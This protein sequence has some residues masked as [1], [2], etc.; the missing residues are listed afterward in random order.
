MM[1]ADPRAL[2]EAVEGGLEATAEDLRVAKTCL[3]LAPPA[4]GA[5][6]FHCQ[7]AIEKLLKGFLML[8]AK[9]SRKTH[10]L[11]QLSAA[12]EASFP[13]ISDL[14]AAAKD[15]SRWAV[16]FR[17]PT[18]RGRIKPAPDEDELRRALLVI[19]ALASRLRAANPEPATRNF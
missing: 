19:D 7:Q 17:Y 2:W 18:R 3:A 11:A 5:A 13:E 4:R 14:V 1:S 15:W 8:A 9:R 6:A 16:D 12:A 10:S